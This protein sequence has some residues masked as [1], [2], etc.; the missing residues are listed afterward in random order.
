MSHPSTGRR[1]GLT[2][3]PG[4]RATGLATG[5]ATRLGRSAGRAIDHLLPPRLRTA[6]P[7]VR[8]RARFLAALA[9]I[10]LVPTKMVL[11]VALSA[12][13]TQIVLPTVL[14]TALLVV[15]LILLWRRGRVE[16]P[17]HLVLASALLFLLWGAYDLRSSV[18]LMGMSV[19]PMAA[20]LLCGRRAGWMWLLVVCVASPA[21]ALAFDIRIPAPHGGPSVRAPA[22]I[23]PMQLAVVVFALGWVYEMLKQRALAELE[24]Q[25]LQALEGERRVHDSE[26]RA[27]EAE[28][29]RAQAEAQGRIQESSRM[30]ALGT[31]SAGVA[32]EI[33]NPLA[34]VM[35]N[36]HFLDEMLQEVAHRLG[37]E[38][39]DEVVEILADTV[40]GLS[41]I[42]RIVRDLGTFSR[43]GERDDLAAINVRNVMEAALNLA[44]N[45]VGQRATVVREYR[46]AP[47]VLASE[48]RL[49]QVF[50]NLL[51]NAAQAIPE[52]ARE[53]N[54]IRVST[55]TDER[56]HAF[57]EVGDSGVGIPAE[58][59]PRLFDPFFT[60]KAQ[61]EGT[62]LGLSIC[63]G[64]VSELGGQITV[65]SQ[66]GQGSTFRVTLP[67]G[68]AHARA[69]TQTPPVDS[70]VPARGRI[71]IVDDEPAVARALARL[72]DGHEVHVAGSGREAMAVL[73]SD[74]GFDAIFCDI[75]MA[76][77]SGIDLFAHVQSARPDLAE[78][79]V[80]MTAGT[81]T[82]RAQAFAEEHSRV[83]LEKPLNEGVLQKH[84]CRLLGTVAENRDTTAP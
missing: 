12:G 57:A 81:F 33:N 37:P 23:A 65:Q 10:D 64:I 47:L 74:A 11:I 56:G 79:F 13:W 17:G 22:V 82:P 59:L 18:P 68:A 36:V 25:K 53:T 80:F 54:E 9:V 21:V 63:H 42:R 29:A 48:P 30:V 38:Q 15:A 72:L 40:D 46:P 50:L 2:R 44:R 31:L 3:L 58:H 71:L 20:L 49:A 8:M 14:R 61:G 35:A 43:A 5:L 73:D 76:D 70:P 60:T 24:Q 6:A 34:V 7:E 52:G 51:I 19:L 84:L 26:R 45:H 69:R 83:C 77:V 66:S 55:G 41:R 1:P 16:L 4:A 39:R 28:H 67:P 62:G 27:L 75:M 32:H 78:R